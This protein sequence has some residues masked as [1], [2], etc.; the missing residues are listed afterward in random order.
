LIGLRM[1]GVNG[2]R[3]GICS[4]GGWFIDVA[5]GSDRSTLDHGAVPQA[6]SYTIESTTDGDEQSLAINGVTVARVRNSSLANTAYV[7]IEAA[8]LGPRPGSAVLS[9]FT[10]TPLP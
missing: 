6:G 3:E 5:D 7:L 2:Y 8:G 10:F 4:N 9:D 1:T